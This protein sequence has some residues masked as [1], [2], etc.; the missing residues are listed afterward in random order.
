M[1]FDFSGSGQSEG[2]YVTLGFYESSDTIDVINYALNSGKVSKI[3]LWGRSMVYYIK[4]GAFT[5][6]FAACKEPNISCI[7]CDSPYKSLS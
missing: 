4:K 6:L 2:E 1:C 5:A 3:A 7:V